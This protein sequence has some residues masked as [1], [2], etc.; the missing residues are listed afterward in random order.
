MPSPAY[1]YPILTV[2]GLELAARSLSSQHQF[3][4]IVSSVGFPYTAAAAHVFLFQFLKEKVDGPKSPKQ[5]INQ[6]RD[7]AA[8]TRKDPNTGETTQTQTSGGTTVG[9]TMTNITTVTVGN[10]VTVVDNEP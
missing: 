5:K 7:S 4:L 6:V 8:T 2:P 10:D 9:D 3:S 1:T